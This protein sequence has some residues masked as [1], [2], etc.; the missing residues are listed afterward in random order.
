MKVQLHENNWTVLI[1]DLDLKKATVEQAHEIARLLTTN[2]VV[3]VRDQ[4]L[5]PQDEVD[6]CSKIGKVESFKGRKEEA[7]KN[8]MFEITSK[9]TGFLV[10]ETDD[11]VIRVTGEKDELGRPGLFGHVSDLD[12]HCNQAANPWRDPIVWL[13]GVKGTA[14]SRTSWINTI[15][16]YDDLSEDKKDEYDEIQTVNAYKAGG[17]SPDFFYKEVDINYHWNPNIVQTNVAGKTGLFFPFLQMHEVVGMTEEESRNFIIEVR[18]HLLQ[19]KYMYHH[20]WRDG[21]VVISEQWL[22][23]HKRWKF[24]DIENRVL[25]RICFNFDN[26]DF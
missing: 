3:V 8:Q 5:S 25:H 17:Y 18:D 9:L 15:L 7:E 12:W 23:L 16:C 13:Y 4:D 6:F 10:P 19:D 22:G 11:Q 14:G 1:E 26:V 2:T 20:D 21:D 24:E